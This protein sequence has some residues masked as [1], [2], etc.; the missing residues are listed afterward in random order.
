M[1]F[2]TD[3]QNKVAEAVAT[4]AAQQQ[5]Q[6]QTGGAAL[7]LAK[8]L[9]DER[10]DGVGREGL[11]MMIMLIT[12]DV[13]AGQDGF[14]GK[15]FECGPMRLTREDTEALKEYA[16]AFFTRKETGSE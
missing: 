10:V 13:N 7:S 6:A 16:D 1:N 9:F 15:K 12:Y 3:L 4:A 2:I 5:P 8:Q 11:P 14:S